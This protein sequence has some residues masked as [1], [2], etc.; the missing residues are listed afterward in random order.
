MGR[1]LTINECQER[2]KNKGGE[3]LSEIYEN[4]STEMKWKCSDGHEWMATFHN[5]KKGRWCPPCAHKEKADKH[6]LTIGECQEVARSKGG[7]CLSEVYKNARTKMKWKCHKNHEWEAS[8][9]HIKNDNTWCPSCAG[10]AK[11]TIKEC[12]EHAKNK[13]G[14]CLSDEYKNCE[15]KLKWRCHKNHEW[16][17]MFSHIKTGCWC[18]SCAY[19]NN[20]D[21]H[22]LTI[23]EC[24]EVARSKSGEC[25]SEEYKHSKDKMKWR[26]HKNHEWEATFDHIKRGSWC[27]RCSALRSE[28]LAC[29][30]LE[31]ET[32]YKWIKIRP[33]W[34]EHLEL[35]GY[36]EELNLAFEY[37]G[38]QHY[39]YEPYFHRNGIEDFHIQQEHDERK[40][41]ITMERGIKIIFIPYHFNYKNPDEMKIY[42]KDQLLIMKMLDKL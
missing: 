41:R 5:I 11:L 22:R 6:R 25:L 8:F 30:I 4:N 28:K 3:C 34:L 38:Q 23:G 21:K 29:D 2:A 18:P 17:A 33:D 24:Q 7:E 36:C 19:K 40:L 1:R 15:T 16:E 31:D 10:N 32:N 9:N 14:E 20:A 12:Q 27:P 42:L 37:Q 13:G 39:R 35:D 26:C